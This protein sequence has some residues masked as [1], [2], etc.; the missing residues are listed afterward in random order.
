MKSKQTKAMFVTSGGGHWIQ[1][2]RLRTA[3]SDSENTFVTVDKSYRSDVQHENFHIV[4]DASRD[5]PFSVL[6]LLFQLISL[7]HNIKPDVIITTGA[8]PG[9]IAIIIGHLFGIKTLFID[10]IA[11]TKKLSLSARI[12]SPFTD[13][14]LTQWPDL[15]KKTNAIYRGNVI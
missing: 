4:T 10:S 6:R 7:I 9:C 14:L 8:A 13:K 2:M 12:A 11:N 5:T 15:Q 1:L 3:F